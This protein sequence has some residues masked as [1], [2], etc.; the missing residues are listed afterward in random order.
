MKKVLKRLGLLKMVLEK[1][2]QPLSSRLSEREKGKIDRI[3][4]SE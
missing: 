1:V 3:E 4:E 2:F